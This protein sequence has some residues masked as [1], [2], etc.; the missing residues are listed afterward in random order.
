MTTCVA[1]QTRQALYMM[2]NSTYIRNKEAIIEIEL[3][4]RRKCMPILLDIKP[5]GI[6]LINIEDH[7]YF[8]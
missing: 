8:R 2:K 1:K 5:G 3:T 6:V 4:N 7:I